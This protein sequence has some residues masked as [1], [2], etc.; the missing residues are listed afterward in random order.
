MYVLYISHLFQQF[1]ILLIQFRHKMQTLA[2]LICVYFRSTL[3]QIQI[4]FPSTNPVISP[5]SRS[6]NNRNFSK[7]LFQRTTYLCRHVFP[8]S[9]QQFYNPFFYSSIGNGVL[10]HPILQTRRSRVDYKSAF[11][12]R[13]TKTSATIF[14]ETHHGSPN[15][16]LEK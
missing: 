12:V 4:S 10:A 3:T 14:S 11:L 2:F 5:I 1:L 9:W 15:F 6:V 13:A 7:Y 8:P 16:Q